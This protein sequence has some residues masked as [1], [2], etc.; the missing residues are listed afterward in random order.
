MVKMKDGYIFCQ[1]CTEKTTDCYC[2]KCSHFAPKG[3]FEK[4]Y[5]KCE[6]CKTAYVDAYYNCPNCRSSNPKFKYKKYS[7]QPST[8]PHE[9][10]KGFLFLFVGIPLIILVP[11]FDIF[12]DETCQ[13]KERIR[14]AVEREYM[15]EMERRYNLR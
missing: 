9:V 7:V 8:E 10:I 1:N 14:Q 3:K 5:V 2:P 15:F 11:W 4:K 6:S 13:R 12:C